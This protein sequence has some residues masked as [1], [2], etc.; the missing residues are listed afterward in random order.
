MASCPRCG[1][2]NPEAARFCAACGAELPPAQAMPLETRRTVTV[3]FCDVT[4]S[5]ALGERQDPEQ[6][7]RV[8]SRYF[9]VSREV[10]RR[11]GGTVEK[12]MGDAVM[13]VFGVPVLHEDDA[14]RALRAAVEL[15]DGI[16]LL[17]EDL[18]QTYGV[19]IA[20]RIGVNSGEVIAGDTLRGHSFAAGDAVNVAQRLEAAAEAG[21]ILIGEMTHALARDAIHAEPTGP[22]A[23]KGRAEAVTAFR[24]TEV[25]PGVPGHARRFDSPMIGRE[26]EQQVLADTFVRAVAERSCHLFTVLGAA[27]V[28]KSRLVREAV[29]QIGDRARLLVGTCLPYGEGITFWPVLE[30]VKQGTGIVDGD[31]SQQAIAKIEAA[32]AGDEAAGLAAERV[33]A[34]V[35]LEESGETAEQGFWGFRKL[36]ETL[37][38]KQ[39]TILVFDDVNTGEPHFLDLVEYLAERARDVPLLIVC[40][41][42]PELL[43]A[44]RAWAGGMRNATTIFLEPLSRDESRTLLDNLLAVDVD[45][46]L[47]ARI[48]QSAEGNPLFVE[49]MV[50]MLID[51]GYLGADGNGAHGELERL[52]V[53]ASIQVL[54]ASRLDQLSGG[55]RQAIE[56]A[57]VEGAVFHSGAVA[58]LADDELRGEVDDCLDSLVRK[59]LIGPY[60]ASFAG[61]DGFRFRHVLIREAAYEAVP[62]Q[63]RAEL[64]ERYAAWLEDVAGDRLPELEEVLGYHLEQA[65]RYRL[66]V[67]RA[68]EHGRAL[69]VRAGI[70][71]AA[72]GR[73]ALAR[74]DA[75]AAANLLERAARLLPAETAERRTLMLVRAEALREIGEFGAAEAT[76]EETLVAAAE[77]GDAGVEASARL[78]LACLRPF[79]DP[80]TATAAEILGQAERAVAVFEQ[81]GYDAGLA[82]AYRRIA[83]VHWLGCRVGEAQP[84]LGRALEH[85]LRAGDRRELSSIRYALIRAAALGPTPVEEAI[86]SSRRIVEAADGEPLIEAVGA[87]A[88]AY[89]EAARRRFDEAR[90]LAAR[91]HTI[92]EELGLTIMLPT[93]DAWTGEIEML[94]GDPAAAERLWREAYDT[95]AAVGE[96]GNMS[97]I[98]AFLAEALH[99]QGRDEEAE[100][101]TAVSEQ[102]AFRD[103]VTSQIAWR[104]TRAR[105]RARLGDIDHAEVLARE[106]A[107][108]AAATDWPSLRVAGLLSVAEVLV[109]AGRVEEA[110]ASAHEAAGVLAA[111]GNVAGATRAGSLLARSPFSEAAP[112]EPAS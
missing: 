16:D 60:R 87:N 101:L 65:Y 81:L 19:R 23:L 110:T 50:S 40:M 20:V 57:A 12:F 100:E 2:R 33:A 24:L 17:N 68:D 38:R 67:L 62:K 75:S 77:E 7:R 76:L 11:H 46:Q 55:E 5:T 59:E 97:T 18:E 42:R 58:A 84:A 105:I 91:S 9:E 53:P 83:D 29:G 112:A 99:V 63:L 14:L 104:A 73:R 30:V 37:A 70:R 107:R 85:A 13:A 6:V 98:A 27:G 34:L 10:L 109:T 35:G 71:L 8:M 15:R 106:A 28:G 108:R 72:A 69:G 44:R 95:L 93:L 31:S 21:E 102:Y 49:E 47:V 94:A 86:E 26:R 92:L 79:V 66:D 36:V 39:P 80:E 103:D 54:L 90:A 48:Q 96:K 56:R 4:G 51:G 41:A 25:L 61:V 82:H 45:E 43:D 22:L 32:L 74:G 52:P 3:L 89:L 64:H 78:E 88:L 1:E 111:K